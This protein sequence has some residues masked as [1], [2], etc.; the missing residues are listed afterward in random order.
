VTKEFLPNLYCIEQF[1]GYF[2]SILTIFKNLFTI[3][4]KPFMGSLPLMLNLLWDD[5]H[6]CHIKKMEK[7]TLVGLEL[8]PSFDVSSP[9]KY[10]PQSH[11][12]ILNKGMKY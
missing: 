11:E 3:K 7:K 4:A 9:P 10:C 2:F 5:C 1:F 8:H 6:L 12:V